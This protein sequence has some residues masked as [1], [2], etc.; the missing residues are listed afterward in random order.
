MDSNPTP[1]PAPAAPAAPKPLA[2]VMVKPPKA[3]PQRYVVKEVIQETADVKS[4]RVG[5]ENGGPV[6]PFQP[7]QFVDLHLANADGQSWSPYYAPYSI[8]SS[9]TEKGYYELTYKIKGLFTQAL[10]KLK[11]GDL[12]GCSAPQGKNYYHEGEEMVHVAGGIGVTPCMGMLRY[13]TATNSKS[14]IL[15]LY[16]NRTPADIVYHQE[17]HALLKKNS[18]LKVI[19]T[20]TRCPPEQAPDGCETGRIDEAFLRR[21]VQNPAGKHWF[22]CGGI[23][24]TRELLK[25]LRGPLG[26]NFKNIHFESWG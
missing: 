21:H 3:P 13:A 19:H 25:T 24:M 18:N 2:P 20:L 4:L 7:G 26:V 10:A 11:A 22:L 14:K 5:P 17:M 6:V 12:I 15:L 16:S 1:A 9:P 23:E 8:A